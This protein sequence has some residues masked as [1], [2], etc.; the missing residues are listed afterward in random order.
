[1]AIVS[2]PSDS[3]SGSKTFIFTSSLIGR[4]TLFVD[5]PVTSR[6]LNY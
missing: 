6:S 5:E 3:I 2:T 1:V 4:K